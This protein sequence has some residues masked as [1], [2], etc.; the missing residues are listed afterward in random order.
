MD[1]MVN[2]SLVLSMMVAGVWTGAGFAADWPQWR[3]LNRD[4]VWTEAGLVERFE[5]AQLPVK[6]RV[7]LGSGYGG[8][9]VAAGRV[10]VMDRV[11]QPA[12]QERIQCFEAETGKP[13]WSYAY[14]CVYERIQYEAGPRASVTIHEGRAY[15][16]GTMGHL[17]CLDAQSGQVLWSHDCRKE[18]AARVP[19]WG[20]AG[21]PLVEG[22]LLLAPVGGKDNACLMAFDPATGQEKWRAL[23][24]GVSYSAPIIIA[25][26]GRRVLVYITDQRIVGLDP[27]TGQLHWEH[28]F[29][30]KEMEITIATPVFDGK[31]LVVTSFYDGMVVLTV[32]PDKLAVEQ[33]WQRR[34]ESEVKTD[35]LHCCISTPILQ[36]EHIYGVDSHGELRCL[37]LQ[38]GDRIWEDLRA[39]PKARWSNIHLVRNA[40]K[41]WMFNERGELLLARLAPDGFHEISRTKLLDPTT[42]QL[43][44]RGGVCWSHPA[45]ANRC[46]YARNDKELVCADLSARP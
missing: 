10:F 11:V 33:L 35:A 19:I 18:Y 42:A 12:R 44:Q 38:T 21:A 8:P 37:A 23:K 5:G 24:E 32:N 9:T 20:I 43:S 34:G 46:I 30:P 16:L 4:G 36:G 6:W 1:K 45:F 14:D 3:G 39:V 28:P 17:H 27:Q 31:H 41:V 22:N 15:S 13:L 7:P 2:K 40:D 26:A 29:V 25:Q